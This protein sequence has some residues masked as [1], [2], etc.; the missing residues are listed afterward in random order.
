MPTL[1][2]I[3]KDAVVNHHLQVPFHQAIKRNIERF[4]EDCLFRLTEKEKNE[5]VT[6]CDHLTLLKYSPKLPLAFSEHGA[7]M[8]AMVLLRSLLDGL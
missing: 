3:G 5:V 2:W 6:N 4:P 8:A 1:N 7:I